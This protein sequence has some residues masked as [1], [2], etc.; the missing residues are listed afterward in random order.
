NICFS[1]SDSFGALETTGSGSMGRGVGAVCSW[2][3]ILLIS[4]SGDGVGRGVTATG[5]RGASAG[6]FFRDSSAFCSASRICRSG[7]FG[8]VRSGFGVTLVGGWYSLKG[9]SGRSGSTGAA[10][11]ATCLGN[12]IFC[13]SFSE[14]V[15]RS[16]VFG[17]T[18]GGCAGDATGLAGGGVTDAGAFAI[19]GGGGALTGCFATG[20][21]GAVRA[22]LGLGAG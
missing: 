2:L 5:R 14:S 8:V 4:A 16:R 10:A 19:G 17:K 22:S 11:E 7:V 9:R 21:T 20:D 13:T 12:A 1:S 3:S 6:G 18:I 15:R